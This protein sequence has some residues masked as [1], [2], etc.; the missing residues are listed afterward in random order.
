MVVSPRHNFTRDAFINPAG[1]AEIFTKTVPVLTQPFE[2]VPVTVNVVAVSKYDFVNT[3]VPV[4]FERPLAG[5]QVYPVP[6]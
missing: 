3:V 4:V 2:S 6:A 5:A 1:L